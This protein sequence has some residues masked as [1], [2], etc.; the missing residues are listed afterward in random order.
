MRPLVRK[1]LFSVGMI[2][3]TAGTPISI[4]A[5][6]ASEKVVISFAISLCGRMEGIVDGDKTSD[7]FI[8]QALVRD[9]LT[10]DQVVNI[11]TP[12]E[13]F[14]TLV[15]SYINRLGGCSGVLKP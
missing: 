14:M 3:A 4:Y 13:E 11:M 10:R 1:V 7:F 6:T 5:L 8:E 2:V 9:G 15:K 12:R